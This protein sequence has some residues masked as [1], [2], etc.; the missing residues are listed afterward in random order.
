MCKPRLVLMNVMS[1]WKVWDCQVDSLCI[2][3]R[4]RKKEPFKLTARMKGYTAVLL[5]LVGMLTG[6]LFIRTEVEA[7]IL[8]LQ[9][10]YFNI[11]GKT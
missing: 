2:R 7:V 5:I 4:N 3:R 10:N 1:L 9:V 11:K 8:R 6:L